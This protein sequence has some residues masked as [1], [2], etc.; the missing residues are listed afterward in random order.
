MPITPNLLR[1]LA[2]IFYDL[3]L[4]LSVLFVATALILPFNAGQAFTQHSLYSL[5]LLIVS[6]IFYGWFWTHGG[7]TLG[8]RAWK[9]QI[10]TTN[11]K[12]LT[13]RHALLR[14]VSAIISWCALGSGFWW[15]LISKN[16]RCW[17]DIFSK[18]DI[19]YKN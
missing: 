16:K 15:S 4:L 8:L 7:Q 17:H 14:F 10:L 11:Q 5:Y 3:L 19:F 13:W 2:A 9:L 1:R 6:F 18:T 12:P